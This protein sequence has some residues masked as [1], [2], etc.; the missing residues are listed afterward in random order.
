MCFALKNCKGYYNEE[1]VTQ[2]IQV[3][4]VKINKEDY[5]KSEIISG[6]IQGKVDASFNET[7]FRNVISESA[8]SL[9]V[10]CSSENYFVYSKYVLT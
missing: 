2:R 3:K 6:R 7:E 5:R 4:Y 1:E 8:L 10:L 9:C